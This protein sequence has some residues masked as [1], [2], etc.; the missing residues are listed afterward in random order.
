MMVSHKA[1][2]LKAI[3]HLHAKLVGPE[4]IDPLTRRHLIATVEY[5]R[6][7]VEAIEELKKKRRRT[8][9]AETTSGAA[10]EEEGHGS[11]H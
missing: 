7:E 11:K 1:E 3:F 2:A 9:A 6:A 4:P 8:P 10:G 5:A